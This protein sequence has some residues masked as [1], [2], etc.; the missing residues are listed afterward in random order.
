M[1]Y[2]VECNSCTQKAWANNIVDLIQDHTD[3]LGRLKCNICGNDDA[4]I[5]RES[6][7]QEKGDFWIRYIKGVIRI[8]TDYETYSPY[9]FLTTEDKD[10]DI[11]GI[12]FNYY[13][14]TRSEPDGKLKHGA[15]PGGAPVFKKDE[16][17][18]LIKKL[19]NYGCF[20]VEDLKKLIDDINTME[21]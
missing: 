15:G 9:V 17:I 5:Y 14:D 1:G 21:A 8:L 2:L 12:H 10:S 6:M 11:T 4:F 7:L 13:K 18:F 20:S 16:L 3:E 19:I